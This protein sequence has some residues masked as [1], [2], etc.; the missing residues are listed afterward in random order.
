MG[1]NYPNPF[2]P[3][4]R[5]PYVVGGEVSS[6]AVPVTLRIYSVTGARVTTLVND[7]RAPGAYNA[8]W[9]GTNDAGQPVVSGIYFA[10]LT[11]GA[12]A[13]LTRKLVLLK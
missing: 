4:T 6:G 7:T 5:I 11:V 1:S 2:N 9:N 8:V 3:T 10:K 12:G 13:V